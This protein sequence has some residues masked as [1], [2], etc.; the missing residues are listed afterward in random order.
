VFVVDT[1]NHND[2]Q[3]FH[4]SHNFIE[5][6]IGR[7]ADHVRPNTLRFGV[8]YCTESDHQQ[9]GLIGFHNSSDAIATIGTTQP[10][11]DFRK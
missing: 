4:Y 9:L 10:D 11:V 5:D 2:Q 3:S 7:M 1:S 8:I 6:V